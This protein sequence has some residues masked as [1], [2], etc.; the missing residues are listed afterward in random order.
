MSDSHR[1]DAIKRIKA[2]REFW[3]NLVWLVVANVVSLTV[4]FMSGRGYFWPGWVLLGTS[5]AAIS[6]GVT[7]F[8]GARPIAE[9]QIQKEIDKYS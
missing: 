3:S 7:V 6:Y 2:K 5:I 1:D 9:D 4:W 8:G